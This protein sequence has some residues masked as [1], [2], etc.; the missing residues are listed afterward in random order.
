[1]VNNSILMQNNNTFFGNSGSTDY[2]SAIHIYD[3]SSSTI[4]N[5]IFWNDS[6]HEQIIGSANITYS[7]VYGGWDGEG[8]INM[9]PLFC[10]PDSNDFTLAENSPAIEIGE[11]V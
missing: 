6:V 3:S 10:N 1:M 8:N 7:N 11:N 2:A 5:S 4:K 9:D